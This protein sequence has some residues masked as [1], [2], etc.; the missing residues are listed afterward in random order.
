MAARYVEIE[1]HILPEHRRIGTKI[2]ATKEYSLD[3]AEPHVVGVWSTYVD[4]NN[5]ANLATALA[6]AIDGGPAIS[7]P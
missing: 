3:R 2:G 1:L 6:A 7:D 4:D 5:I